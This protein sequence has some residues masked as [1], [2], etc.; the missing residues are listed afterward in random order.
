MKKISRDKA[1]ERVKILTN[2]IAKSRQVKN[3]FRFAKNAYR[4]ELEGKTRE[5]K[6]SKL[7]HKILVLDQQ[8]P[9]GTLFISK[10]KENINAYRHSNLKQYDTGINPK[11]LFFLILSM[12]T[13][14]ESNFFEDYK[15]FVNILWE[16]GEKE[17]SEYLRKYWMRGDIEDVLWNVFDQED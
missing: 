8:F 3:L 1:I 9:S 4:E 6:N 15:D 11:A 12:P 2:E 7:Y 13:H 17:L 5:F 10:I 14:E 16:S